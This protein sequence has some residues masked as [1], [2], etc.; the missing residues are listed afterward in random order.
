M[1]G[2]AFFPL[3]IGDHV[4]IEEDCVVNAAQV[5]SYVH[6]GKAEYGSMKLGIASLDD[7][8]FWIT[9]DLQITILVVLVWS[10]NQTGSRNQINS[11]GIIL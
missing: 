8:Q 10:I 2:V 4:L 9:F 5:G 1:K 11:W 6:I 7:G 3:H